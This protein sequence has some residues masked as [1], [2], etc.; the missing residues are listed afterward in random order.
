[1]FKIEIHL[2]D[3][4]ELKMSKGDFIY[5][6]DTD[7]IDTYWEWEKIAP[8]QEKFDA[9]FKEAADIVDRAV[10]RLPDIPM[11]GNR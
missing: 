2:D 9:L 8:T 7:G 3:G 11:P 1:M 4:R 5:Y 6:K 10:R